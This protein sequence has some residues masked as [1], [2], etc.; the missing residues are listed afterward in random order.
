MYRYFFISSLISNVKNLLA[1]D[2]EFPV[3]FTNY[4]FIIRQCKYYFDDIIK[5][6]N[7]RMKVGRKGYIYIYIQGINLYGHKLKEVI[8]QPDQ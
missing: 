4:D 7:G 5:Q 2:K 6:I 8:M 3:T 1:Y